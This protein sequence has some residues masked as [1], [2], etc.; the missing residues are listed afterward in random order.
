MQY[1]IALDTDLWRL[2]HWPRPFLLTTQSF[3]GKQRPICYHLK[4]ALNGKPNHVMLVN[5]FLCS[6][7]LAITDPHLQHNTLYNYQPE[8]LFFSESE[9]IA[10]TLVVA[11]V[12]NKKKHPL[13]PCP[14]LQPSQLHS[15]RLSKVSRNPNRINTSMNSTQHVKLFHFLYC[16]GVLCFHRTISGYGD[17]LRK[18]HNILMTSQRI[19]E[20]L[21]K[22]KKEVSSN[23]W[24]KLR[25][26]LRI[27]TEYYKI[28]FMEKEINP[29]IHERNGRQLNI[30]KLNDLWSR[31]SQAIFD[32]I[33]IDPSQKYCTMMIT[34]RQYRCR[35]KKLST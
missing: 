32:Q 17:G 13:D 3:F 30:F 18:E 1:S 31:K 14:W 33:K 23:C 29:S 28:S 12:Y 9:S 20:H 15:R 10:A 21:Q 4:E 8:S 5:V 16:I 7:V 35:R 25:C 27:L 22:K 19:D 26:L 11:L 2:N 24:L 34:F 6:D